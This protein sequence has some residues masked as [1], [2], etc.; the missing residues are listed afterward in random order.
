M[1]EPTPKN[2][3][4]KNIFDQYVY[5]LN[6]YQEKY[7]EKTV[8]LMQVGG[9]YE[10]YGVDNDK[11]KIGSVKEISAILHIEMTRR[12]KEIKENTRKNHLMA[13]FPLVAITKFLDILIDN[14]YTV[15]IVDQEGTAKDKVKASEKLHRKVVSIESPGTR[16][17]SNEEEHKYLVHIHFEGY[18]RTRK[19]IGKKINYQPTLVGFSAI[20]VTTG[21]NNVYEI[22]NSIE[23]QNYALDEVYRYLQIH[24]PKELIISTNNLDM[25]YEELKNYL[26]LRDNNVHINYNDIPNSYYKLSYQKTFLEK[27]FPAKNNMLSVIE[28][29]NLEKT[30]IALLSYIMLLQFAYEH[31]EIL[32]NNL[33]CPIIWRNEQHLLLANNAISQLELTN[34]NNQSR[35]GSVLNMLNLTSTNMGRRL[36][37]DRLLNPIVDASWLEDRYSKIDLFLKDDFWRNISEKLN[38][39][40]DLSRITRRIELGLLSPNGFNMLYNSYQNVKDLLLELPDQILPSPDFREKFQTYLDYLDSTLDWDETCKYVDVDKIVDNIFKDGY[41][42]DLDEI[43]QKIKLQHKYLDAMVNKMSYAV[44]GIHGTQV[45][46]K[47]F[48]DSSGYFFSITSTRYK[49]MIK[50]LKENPIEYKVADKKFKLT[51]ETFKIIRKNT[52]AT[53]FNLTCESLEEISSSLDESIKE[54]KQMI[55]GTVKITKN[56]EGERETIRTPGVYLKFMIDLFDRFQQM[57]TNI[58]QLIAEV[59][60]YTASAKASVKYHLSRPKI[61]NNTDNSFIRAIKIRHPLI[62]QLNSNSSYVSHNLQLGDT[63]NII[64]INK[65]TD[66]I[67]EKDIQTD[68]N[69]DTD[70]DTDIPTMDGLL[71]F[72]INACG[73]SSLMKAVGVNLVM[74][75]AGM[76]V[77][78]ESF[79]YS[80]Y[81]Q[82]LTR[83]I[84]NDNIFKGL[85]SF[86]VEMSELRGILSRA[87][88][89]TLVLGDEICHGTETISGISIVAASLSQLS[90]KNSHY[91]F[92]THLHKLAELP[93]VTSLKNLKIYHLHVDYD[94]ETHLLVYRRDMQPG[95][96]SPI[97]GIEVAR[98]MDLDQDLITKANKIR[99]KLMDQSSELVSSKQSRYN[100][101]VY[102]DQCMIATCKNR[103]E[104]THHIKFQCTADH[105]GFID[106]THKNEPK[107]LVPLC[108]ECHQAVHAG[109]IN[110]NGYLE[111]SVGIILDYNLSPND[112]I[113]ET[114]FIFKRRKKL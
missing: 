60:V 90:E 73:K 14:Q 6:R 13:G 97:Y 93:E 94:P 1:T 106:A 92:A 111:T 86:A 16:L 98:A 46:Q 3:D 32:V 21:E 55:N 84:G 22:S 19:T 76:F 29:L 85:S 67:T 37:K 107:N 66:I 113:K 17:V 49:A 24:Q 10:L 48:T 74:A 35:F 105:H 110:I 108:K 81:H 53:Q 103:A 72:G 50:T 112:N 26:D 20:D 100:S 114:N 88:N 89:R 99:Q 31:N 95:P 15:V 83:I 36:F 54:L 40:I 28:Y 57:F 9:F 4:K 34:K 58:N 23:D 59:D 18:K 104:D 43:S 42:K 91:I 25:G 109:K 12:N 41:N 96:G 2:L 30:P 33:Q 47:K 77:A 56:E 39:I 71:L 80:P 52:G 62:E 27:L 8:V 79:T 7:G 5:F 51:D 68:T 102:V 78:S 82:I 101:N 65:E 61:I 70:T 11:M 38:G 64:E 75:Q 44:N 69:T 63:K 45:V 87:D